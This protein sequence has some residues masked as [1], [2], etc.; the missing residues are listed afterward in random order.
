[1][2]FK[3]V[4]PE[5]APIKKHLFLQGNIA[6]GKSTLLRQALLPHLEKV[7]GF[8]V[9]RIYTGNEHTGFQLKPLCDANDYQL[10]KYVDCQLEKEK[11]FIYRDDDLKMRI[12]LAIFENEGVSFLKRNQEKMKKLILMDEIGG[13]DLYCPAF[14]RSVQQT[15]NGPQSVIGVLKLTSHR[16][17][18]SNNLVNPGEKEKEIVKNFSAIRN[19]PLVEIVEF[20]RDRYKE[21]QTR[22]QAFVNV[23]LQPLNRPQKS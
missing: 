18:L 1:M 19:H 9:Q 3:S 14:M 7:G 17:R 13:V 11:L 8:F 5:V 16:K 10:N 15:L 21:V 2:P 23:A 22:V 12:N 6:T 20:S 4:L